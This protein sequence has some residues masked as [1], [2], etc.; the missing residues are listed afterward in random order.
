MKA[1]RPTADIYGHVSL[2]RTQR[3]YMVQTEVRGHCISGSMTSIS[4]CVCVQ[5]QYF[6][7]YEAVAE[8]IVCGDTEV[9]LEQLEEYVADI[10]S[11]AHEISDSTNIEL[12]FKVSGSG[13]ER[14]GGR[15]REGGLTHCP[16]LA[17][18]G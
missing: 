11:V 17:H 6:F 8:V 9:P 4:L 13:R 7:I 18:R 15:G 2:L 14:E 3:N 5:D 12:Q 1:D 10:L 16:S